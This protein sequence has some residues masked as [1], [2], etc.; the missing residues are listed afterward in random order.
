MVINDIV[1][2]KTV[3]ELLCYDKYQRVSRPKTKEGAFEVFMGSKFGGAIT[4]EK[5]NDESIIVRLVRPGRCFE[6]TLIPGS[7]N[8]E[9]ALCDYNKGVSV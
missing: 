2:V 5:H 4:L 9:S 1:E 8:Y 3:E 6:D 7:T